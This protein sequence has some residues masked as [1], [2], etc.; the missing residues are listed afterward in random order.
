MSPH[1][2]HI[3]VLE[4]RAT[5]VEADDVFF[6]HYLIE[7]RTPVDIPTGAIVELE[8][9]EYT[10]NDLGCA[11][12]EVERMYYSYLPQGVFGAE[13]GGLHPEI[14]Y[15][16]MHPKILG[17]SH[18]EVQD[19][20]PAHVVQALR[21]QGFN[22]AGITLGAVRHAEFES[23]DDLAS[24]IRMYQQRAQ[25]LATHSIVAAGNASLNWDDFPNNLPCEFRFTS[26]NIPEFDTPEALNAAIEKI[27]AEATATYERLLVE[28]PDFKQREE[29]AK[30][31]LRALR[32]KRET[33][34]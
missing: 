26:E 24:F 8:V 21:D 6:G 12:V 10:L 30:A 25:W 28:N 34:L 9:P 31:K 29:A 23:I 15:T 11:V 7:G 22:E 20:A 13:W 2:Q 32:E 19:K 3:E 5:E 17:L 16:D 18:R 1:K 33:N 27:D 14:I 4:G